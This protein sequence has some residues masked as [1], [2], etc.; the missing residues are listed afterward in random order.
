MNIDF[1]EKSYTVNFSMS[2]EQKSGWPLTFLIGGSLVVVP[3]AVYEMWRRGN[4]GASASKNPFTPESEGGPT[5]TDQ[6]SRGSDFDGDGRRI[7]S[8]GGADEQTKSRG[9][10]DEDDDDFSSGGG[11]TGDGAYGPGGV[12]SDFDAYVV[13]VGITL[14]CLAAVLVLVYGMT[15]SGSS[16]AVHA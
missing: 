10:F 13:P 8:R 5:R 6:V 7:S 1:V 15:R 3:L 4:W 14:L 11:A 9:L 12:D 2:R 16:N